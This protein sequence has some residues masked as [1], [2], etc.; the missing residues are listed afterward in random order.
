[1]S[2]LANIADMLLNSIKE[3]LG[4]NGLKVYPNSFSQHEKVNLLMIKSGHTKY[5]VAAGSGSL[6]DE[7]EG[8]PTDGYK[9][10]PLSHANRL[11]LNQYFP[12]TAPGAFGSKTATIGLGDRLGIASPGHIKVVQGRKIK[13][14][15]AQQSIRE[16]KL[17]NRNY[18]QVLDAACYAAFQEGYKAGFGADGDHL[19]KEEDI[20]MSL[21]LGFTMLTLDCSEKID[22]TI[23]RSSD[24]EIESKYSRLPVAIRKDYEERYLNHKFRVAEHTIRFDRFR[25]MK[26]VLIYGEAIQFMV[27]IYDR[28]IKNAGREIDFEISIDETLTPTEPASH[29]FV[30]NELYAKRMDIYS[31]APRFCGEFQKGIDYIGDRVQ[32]EQELQVHAAIADYFGYKLSFHSGSDKFSVFPLI[33]KYTKGRFHLKTAGTNWLEA[34]RTVAKENPQLYRR[35]HAYALEHYREALAYYH[36]SMNANKIKPLDQVP[37][38]QLSHYMDEDN[39]RQLI[40]I[41]YGILLQAVDEKGNSLF[42]DEIYRTL[43]EH[44]EAYANGLI[45]LIGRHLELLGK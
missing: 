6:Y 11:L 28:Y 45:S 18:K 40:H 41:T 33:A 39:A 42:K 16:L 38:E 29:Y 37:D 43:S 17:T 31:M 12:Y 44:E 19:K 23:E 36:V 27:Y 26:D 24:E 9:L 20:Q 13:P 30:A 2:Q 15:L 3:I 34:I 22:N 21:D 7:L 4:D 8:E 1:M 10:C 25:L 32:F 5:I 14:I 35:M